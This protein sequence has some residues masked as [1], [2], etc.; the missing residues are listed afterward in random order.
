MTLLDEI[1]QEAWHILTALYMYQRMAESAAKSAT[2]YE[3]ANN[4]VALNSLAEMLVIRVA[5]LADKTKGTRSVSMLLKRSNF[6][7]RTEPVEQAA[8]NFLS[9][10][11]PVVKIRHEQVAH[12]RLGVLSSY[13]LEPLPNV[14]IR[15]TEALIDLIDIARGKAISY[16][17]QVGSVDA[18]I[19]LRASLA[20]GSVVTA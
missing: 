6:A 12:M 15:A 8:E 13:P 7:E 5:R 17:Y 14:V 19:D 18:K 9:L 11:A 10:S 4:I 16:V 20:S 2:R 3:L 1:Q